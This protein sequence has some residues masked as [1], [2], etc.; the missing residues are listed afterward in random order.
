[1]TDVGAR[2]IAPDS[3]NVLSSVLRRYFP[4]V[5]L[6]VPFWNRD[7]YRAISR[8][9][10]ARE[11]VDGPDLAQLR[12]A[13]LDRPGVGDAVLCASGSLALELALLACGVRIRRRSDHADFLLQRG[14]ACRFS[15]AARFPC[16]PMW[17]RN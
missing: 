4:Y 14:G 17:A 16:W 7:T 5:P 3:P 10:L 15:P 1:M 12:D 13:V 9:L 11:I 8:C 2:F 6:A